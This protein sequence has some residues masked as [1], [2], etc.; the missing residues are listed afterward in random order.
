MVLS[1]QPKE[2]EVDKVQL[3]KDYVSALNTFDF[4]GIVSKFQDSVRLKE[5]VYES[6]FSR[7]D[8]YHLFQWDSIFQP[9]YE[10]LEIEEAEDGTVKMQVSKA[11][12]RI[13]FLNKKPI[14]TD[15]VVRF[16]GDKIQSVQITDY[17]VFD[18]VTWTNTRKDLLSW[19]N[20]N[21]PELN[22]FLHDQTKQG[23]LNYMKA[24]EYYQASH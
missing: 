15:E 7:E 21:H 17:V 8:Y 5:I 14:I 20:A 18:E 24:L 23:A 6:H 11:G 4:E 10:I 13:L 12:P 9:K 22:G 1:C 2:K 3:V 19:I 16:E